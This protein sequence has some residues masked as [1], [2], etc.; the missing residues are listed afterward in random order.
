MASGLYSDF[1]VGLPEIEWRD[2]L[3][4][5]LESVYDRILCDDLNYCHNRKHNGITR[6]MSLTEGT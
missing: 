3:S 6:M 4:L 2:I 1:I 5:F